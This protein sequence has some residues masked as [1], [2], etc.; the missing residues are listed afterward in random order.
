MNEID[1]ARLRTLLSE[2]PTATLVDVREADEYAGGHVP[3]AL[4]VPLSELVARAPEVLGL[5]T[6]VHL[7][8]ESGGRS[9]QAAGWLEAQGVESVNVVGGTSAWRRAGHPVEVPGR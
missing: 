2:D 3:G 4:S 1:V 7:V 9:A 8:C 5:P 6:P